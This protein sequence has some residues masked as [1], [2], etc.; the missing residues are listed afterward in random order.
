MDKI[1]IIGGRPLKGQ[2]YIGGA[3]NAA[4]PLMAASLLTDEPVHFR[5]I[6]D[7]ADITSMAILLE[8]LGVDIGQGMDI[9]TTGQLSVP[10]PLMKF[11]A[12]HI[13]TTTA[14]YD[15]VRKMRA[16]ILVLGPLLA[17]MGQSVISMPGGCAIGTRPIDLHL[18]ALEALGAEITLDEG[19]VHARAPKGLKGTTFTF[20]LITVTGT[21]NVLMAACL[22]EGETK[23]INVAREPEVIDLANCLVSM[24]AKINGI[25]TDTLVIEGVDR[26]S[27][28]T[29]TVI[30]DRIETGTYA[31]GALM[32][33]GDV[34]LLNTKLDMLPTF[35]P[36]LQDAGAIIEEL[37]NGLRVS[38]TGRING[39]D[40]MTE[41]Y[42][43][44]P[45][46]LQAQFMA[47]MC[48]ADGASMITETI[49]ENRFM[50]VPELQRLGANIIVHN[51][52]AM[53]RGTK[54]L[55]GA[56]VMATDLRASVSL[57]L[58]GL[59]S[60][61]ETIVNRVYHLDRGYEQV[62]NK[63]AACGIE[64]ERIKGEP[65]EPED[66]RVA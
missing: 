32:T 46:D 8:H 2:I 57:I 53:V 38:S 43:G 33:H 7:L 45:T 26:L 12:H 48:T 27:G 62:E 20:P 29:H 6:P 51:A 28:T 10:T 63:L 42:P 9:D 49:W 37:P 16:S 13:K 60:H 19:Y 34:T 64:I 55:S 65:H 50:H 24:G 59:V 1:R 58:A 17:R 44:F 61:G 22:A 36:T 47:L 23:L 41:P 18:R 4:L 35:I 25:G 56:Q 5:N 3:K 15:L 31:I 66:K 30:P 54:K 21:E 39:V 14:P 52:S 11:H 40:I